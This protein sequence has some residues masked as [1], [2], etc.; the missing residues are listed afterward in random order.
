MIG[1]RDDPV[2]ANIEN[3]CRC[4]AQCGV[5]RS[6]SV[7]PVP[8]KE[9]TSIN[10]RRPYP[11]SGAEHSRAEIHY[12]RGEGCQ[13]HTREEQ[14]EA[15]THAE[16]PADGEETCAKDIGHHSNGVCVLEAV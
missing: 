15:A 2:L 1:P 3:S 16:A 11:S 12:V 7:G 5:H 10:H 13:D 8:G 9:T 4:F 14:N 6:G